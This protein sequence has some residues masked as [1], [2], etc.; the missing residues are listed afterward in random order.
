MVGVVV[1]WRTFES[2]QSYGEI[3]AE[4]VLDV[5]AGLVP[6]P[7]SRAW[8]NARVVE[9]RR[10]WL[11]EAG[12]AREVASLA[13]ATAD[14]LAEVHPSADAVYHAAVAAAYAELLADQAEDPG[15]DG[16]VPVRASA[17]AIGPLLHVGVSGELFVDLGM[18]IK[19]RLGDDRTCVAALCDGTVGYL[20]TAEAYE[21]GGYEP[22]ASVLAAGEAERLVDAVVALALAA[23]AA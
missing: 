15:R 5:R 6:V 10:K 2:A 21:V 18:Q 13:R 19:S 9:L 20:P 22:N 17:L 14:R 11:P 8:G 23:P 12:A 3:L 4:C 1:P 16:P 7:S